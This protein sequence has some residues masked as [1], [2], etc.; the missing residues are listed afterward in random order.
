MNIYIMVDLE[1]ISGIFEPSQVM[2][3]GVKYQ[4]GRSLMAADINACVKACKEAGAEKVYVRDCHAG[5]NNV[6]WSN[7]CDDAD[8]YIIGA[9]RQER[10]PGLD[11]CDGVILLGYHAMA[12]TKNAILEHT[13]SSKNVQNFWINGKK[14]GEVAV[15]SGIVGD[16]GR[17]V[18]M[19][20]GDD[21]V[22][23]EARELLPNVVTAEV[24]KGLGCFGGMLLPP[25]KAYAVIREKTIAAVKNLGKQKPLVFDKPILLRVEVT[26]RTQ[27]PNQ[28]AQALYEGHR[29]QDI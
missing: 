22:C 14:A 6:I 15:D 3:D 24:K 28:Y 21:K 11:D 12:G 1:G 17:P 19:V 26:E 25:R 8:Y 16:Y 29:C 4:E 5:G 13:F 7:L 20:S 10:F 9:T 18:I 2:S 23:R 27:L